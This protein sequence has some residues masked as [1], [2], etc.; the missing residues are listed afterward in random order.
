MFYERVAK[1]LKA[2]DTS[3]HHYGPIIHVLSLDAL[4]TGEVCAGTE[5]VED[6][7]KV[8]VFIN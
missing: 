2:W 8:K 1:C 3:A 6:R 7:N 4:A 5:Q